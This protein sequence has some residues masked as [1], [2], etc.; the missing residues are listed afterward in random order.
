MNDE[1]KKDYVVSG[2]VQ[3][4]GFVVVKATSPE[5]AKSKARTLF[6]SGDIIPRKH[7]ICEGTVL[8][9]VFK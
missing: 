9:K 7:E 1:E 5:E 2:V 6:C 3:T 4:T 8:A